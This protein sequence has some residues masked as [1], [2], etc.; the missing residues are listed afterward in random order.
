MK[1]DQGPDGAQPEP[2][3]SLDVDH[4]LSIDRSA[5]HVPVETL[6]DQFANADHRGTLIVGDHRRV[7]TMNAAAR[8][9]L[10]YDGPL[11]RA[12]GEVS[13]N[14]E[15]EFSVGDAIHDRRPLWYEAFAP[16]P[17]RILRFHVIPILTATGQPTVAMVTVDDIT[18]LR[19]LETVRRDFVANVSHE[20]RT[21]IASIN[22]LVETLQRGAVADPEVAH[23]FLHR[24]EV[25]TQAMAH[26]VEELLEL[27]RLE[28][29]VLSLDLSA[30]DLEILIRDVVARLAATAKEKDVSLVLDVRH[31]LPPVRADRRRME[32]VLMNLVH[33]AVKFTPSGGRVTVR[34][35]RKGR[36]VAVEVVDTG[37][38]M[39][40]EQA[41]RIFERFYKVDKGRNRGAGAGLGLAITK[42]LLELHGSALSV[43]TEAG[44]GSKFSFALPS[45]DVPEADDY[46]P[47]P[48]R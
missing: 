26:L 25:E 39:D 32:Q 4:A 2:W 14:V 48:T 9:L 35:M 30:I 43:V 24:I 33:N 23:G 44:R 5:E 12:A 16:D 41:A 28:T 11:P 47:G 21:P 22:L 36:G 42:H 38:G 31:E 17:D 7:L 45:A 20:L 13:R 19:H 6:F 10:A 18:R 37:V 1:A 46:R 15:L 3:T 27:S 34:S 40:S 8:R 29:G